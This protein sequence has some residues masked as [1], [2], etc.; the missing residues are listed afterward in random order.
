MGIRASGEIIKLTSTDTSTDLNGT[1]AVPWNMQ[2]N[3]AGGIFT[4][5]TETN[6]SRITVGTDCEVRVT[7]SVA[8]TSATARSAPYIRFRINGT[9]YEPGRSTI[10]YMRNTGT[11]NDNAGLNLSARFE[12]AASDYIEVIALA[13]G[14]SGTVNLIASESSL[15]I[16]RI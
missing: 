12:V 13:G 15:L 10:G 8:V 3:Y 14:A 11:G 4:H 5:S 1:V 2:S 7:A 9:T 16:E 6:N